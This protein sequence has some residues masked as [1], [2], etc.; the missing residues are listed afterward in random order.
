MWERRHAAS[1]EILTCAIS[2]SLSHKT[3]GG[4]ERRQTENQA[5]YSKYKSYKKM[6]GCGI[7]ETYEVKGQS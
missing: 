6:C 2:A 4:D 1:D 3:T 5:A 7:Y